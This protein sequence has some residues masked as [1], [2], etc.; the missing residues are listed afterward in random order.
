MYSILLSRLIHQDKVMGYRL[1]L[2]FSHSDVLYVE[3]YRPLAP[4]SCQST[5]VGIGGSSVNVGRSRFEVAKII[6]FFTAGVNV[7]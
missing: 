1:N 5:H 2:P 7:V 4:V 3:K 6:S